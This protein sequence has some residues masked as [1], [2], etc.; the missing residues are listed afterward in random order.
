[1]AKQSAGILLYHQAGNEVEVLLVHPGGPFWAR[2]DAGVWSIP[3]GEY[4]TE[5]ALEAAKREI[6]EELG[7]DSTYANYVPL[8]QAKLKSG[9]VN[10]ACAAEGDLDVSK[11]KSNTFD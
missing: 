3:N 10:S 7:I 8:G 5:D 2:K 11:I 4:T 9:K 1:M 6:G